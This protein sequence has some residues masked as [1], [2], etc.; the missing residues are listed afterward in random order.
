[1]ALRARL[2]KQLIVFNLTL[3]QLYL[4]AERICRSCL[5]LSIEGTVWRTNRQVYLL[6]RWERHL[7]GFPHLGVVDRWLATPTT[8][9]VLAIPVAAATFNFPFSVPYGSFNSN[10]NTANRN[11]HSVYTCAN[12]EVSPVVVNPI[13]GIFVGCLDV[14]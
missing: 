8:A 7:A 12:P 13:C 2:C 9:A 10:A 6:Y 4:I 14:C 3:N 5:T 1:M 11:C